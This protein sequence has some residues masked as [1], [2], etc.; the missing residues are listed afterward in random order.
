LAGRV[1]AL[2]LSTRQ[3]STLLSSGSTLSEALGVLVENSS[4][5]RLKSILLEVS[6]SVTGGSSLSKALEAHPEVF[7]T[8][9][10][11]LVA[12]GEASGSLDRVLTRLADYLEARSKIINEVRA[13]LTYPAS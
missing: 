11:G 6:E 12:A 8:F 3:L 1:P 9:Y 2:A 4:N 5:A 7:T 10:R 13:A